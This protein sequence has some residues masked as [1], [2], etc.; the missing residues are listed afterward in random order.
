MKFKKIYLYL[1]FFVIIFLPNYTLAD[2]YLEYEYTLKSLEIQTSDF[3]SKQPSINAKHAVI[4]DRISQSVI[5][6]KNE[7]ET[8]KMASTTK[9]LTAIIVIE[10]CNDLSKL[11]TVSKKAARNWW[12]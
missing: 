7:N 11:V 5:Y 6:G 12:F 1:F 4:Y 9:I 3:S 8:C 2:D 10:N